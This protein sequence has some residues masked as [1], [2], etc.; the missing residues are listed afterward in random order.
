MSM[1]HTLKA[2]IVGIHADYHTGFQR[3]KDKY[4]PQPEPLEPWQQQ[5]LDEAKRPQFESSL[6]KV[7]LS[8]TFS[9]PV[10]LYDF[11]KNRLGKDMK[12]TRPNETKHEDGPEF[13]K[14]VGSYQ[15]PT[16][17]I[18]RVLKQLEDNG[19][20]NLAVLPSYPG[21]P[22]LVLGNGPDDQKNEYEYGTYEVILDDSGT[23]TEVKTHDSVRKL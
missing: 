21:E 6:P 11:A 20:R 16:E 23:V 9:E 2:T 19:W 10:E 13:S 15:A 8:P 14:F 18:T 17:A 1:W 12:R 3:L 5:I 4:Q 7:V 22:I